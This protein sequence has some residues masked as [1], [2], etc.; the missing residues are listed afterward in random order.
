M[1]AL[2]VLNAISQTIA[3]KKGDQGLL[4]Y[5]NAKALFNQQLTLVLY[6]AV[7][8]SIRQRVFPGSDR[9]PEGR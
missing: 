2:A 9:W 6:L 1:I 4:F 3:N 8:I 5:L 7:L